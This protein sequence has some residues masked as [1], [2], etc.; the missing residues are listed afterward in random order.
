[1]DDELKIDYQTYCDLEYLKIDFFNNMGEHIYTTSLPQ[2][3]ENSFTSDIQNMANV[4]KISKPEFYAAQYKFKSGNM[5]K[6]SGK[7]LHVK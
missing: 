4:S 5:K 3:K 7:I 1:M 2:F 6:I